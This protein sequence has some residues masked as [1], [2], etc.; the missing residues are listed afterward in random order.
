MQV[1]WQHVERPIAR[2][3]VTVDRQGGV[4]GI[5]LFGGESFWND[6]I[7]AVDLRSYNGWH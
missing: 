4:R 3:I 5:I 7:S 2:L 1:T 6:L